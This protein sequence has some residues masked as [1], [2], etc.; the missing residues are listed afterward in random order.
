MSR[1]HHMNYL[2]TDDKKLDLKTFGDYLYDNIVLFASSNEGFT[3]ITLGDILDF[4]NGGGNLLFA[5]S[6]IV[7]DG[8][9]LFSESLGVTFDSSQSFIV[10]HFSYDQNVDDRCDNS[11][12]ILRINI[13]NCDLIS[14]TFDF[15]LSLS[16]S[17]VLAYNTINST[18]M[19]SAGVKRVPVLYRGIGHKV[20]TE[21]VLAMKVRYIYAILYVVA[22]VNAIYLLVG[23][24]WQSYDILSPVRERI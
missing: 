9:R 13:K 23:A 16:H 14:F 4:V 18:T 17:S 7:S 19:L 24:F 5:T 22:M 12:Q 1:G 20:D 10:D 2:Q 11:I 21:N 6:S 3:S 8:L 15:S